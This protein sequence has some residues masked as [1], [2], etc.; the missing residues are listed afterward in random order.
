[1]NAVEPR[2]L[3]LVVWFDGDCGF[4]RRVASWL[5]TQETLVPVQ[6][7]AAQRARD[8]GCPIDL[9]SLLAQLTVTASDGAVYRG[10]NAWIVVLWALAQL[11][12][13]RAALRD[14]AMAAVGRAS[15]RCDRRHRVVDE[16]PGRALA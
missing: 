10:T 15:V 3:S 14:A 2:D 7:V 11:P 8:A 1:V 16:T 6:L 4:C 5:Q 12:G 9:A 13:A